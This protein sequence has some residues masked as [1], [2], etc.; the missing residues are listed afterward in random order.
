MEVSSKVVDR[1]VLERASVL[2]RRILDVH[3]RVR[4]RP[5]IELAQRFAEVRILRD[6]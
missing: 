1:T 6:S 2:S 3:E 5:I 4:D